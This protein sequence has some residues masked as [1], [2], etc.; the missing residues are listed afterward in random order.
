MNEDAEMQ[1]EPPDDEAGPPDLR[2]ERM[3][4]A[5]GQGRA[6]ARLTA[7]YDEGPGTELA[8]ELAEVQGPS[9]D[10]LRLP[11]EELTPGERDLVGAL[12]DEITREA[13]EEADLI[14]FWVAWHRAGGFR[15]LESAGWHRTTIFRRTKQFRMRFGRHP[16][17]MEFSWISLHPERCWVQRYQQAIDTARY[18]PEDA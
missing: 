7:F 10:L 9:T 5:E 6:Q 3:D 4:S 13:L 18:G 2:G 11:D 16:D 17:V 8:I 1:L 15:G 14:G 12:R